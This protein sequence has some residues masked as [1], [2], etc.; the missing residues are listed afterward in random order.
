MEDPTT[1]EG[2]IDTRFVY[3]RKT[4]NTDPFVFILNKSPEGLYETKV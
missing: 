2:K 1:K 3:R 4:I